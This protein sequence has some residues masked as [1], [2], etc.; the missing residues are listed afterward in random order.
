MKWLPPNGSSQGSAD[1]RYVV[2]QANSQHWI[3]YD[4][5]GGTTAREIGVRGNDC[6]ARALC[7]GAE[8]A[9]MAE[10]RKRA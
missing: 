9:L 7:E 6:D 8:R 4:I 1:G 3:A 10:T 2:V 5:A